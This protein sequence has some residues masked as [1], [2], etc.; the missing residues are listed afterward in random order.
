MTSTV[1]NPESISRIKKDKFL[2]EMSEDKF[3][4][5]VIRPLFY[6]LG[7]RDGRDLCG[8]LEKGKDAIFVEDNRLGQIDLI[9][10]QTKKGNLNL[11]SKA[12][13]NVTTAITQLTTALQTSVPMLKTKRKCYP[14]KVFLCA[15]GKINEHAKHHILEEVKDPRVTFLDADDL[16]PL[17]DEHLPEL[18]LGID[19]E[20]LPYFRAIKELIEGGKA[21]RSA[22]AQFRIDVLISAAT[23]KTFIP[24][25]LYRTA[26][27][28][29]TVHG[30]TI[31]VPD[32]QEVELTTI[33]KQR[34]RKVLILG[35][36]G[37]GKSTALQR[38]AY[39]MVEKGIR[40]SSD[41]HIPIL[42]RAV[43]IHAAQP[44]SLVEYCD[45]ATKKLAKVSNACF[46]V[47]DL[48]AGRVTLL[49]DA[50]DEV[51]EDR[52]REA[53]VELVS[54]FANDYP[55]VQ[56][57]FTSRPY[58]YV[59]DMGSLHNYEV[60]NIS[61]ISWKQADKIVKNLQRGKKL[62]AVNSK[63]LLRRI[64]QVHGIELNPLLVTVF[65][66]TA[67]YSR[68]DIPA[69]I[70]ELFKKFT[71][72]MLG[73]WDESKGLN[74]QYQA[75]LK[76]FLLTK[77]AFYMHQ[78]E[79]TRITISEFEKLV[80]EQ[81]EVR[82]H[83][84]QVDQITEEVLNRSGLFREV[85]DEVEF[86]HHLLQEFFAG[87]GIPSIDYIKQIIIKDWWKRPIVFFFGERP[88]EIAVLGEVMKA[89]SETGHGK[90]VEAA[91]TVGLAV[92]ACYL[93]AVTE[94]LDAWKWVT[95]TLSLA[96]DTALK[97]VDEDGK[98]PV[99]TFVHYYLYGR[100]SVALSNLRDQSEEI[101]RWI[102]ESSLGNSAEQE[103]KLF[104][105]IVALI[106][107]GEVHT[108]KRLV[109]RFKPGDLRYL[110]AIHLGCFLTEE[111][112]ALG[113]DEKQDAHEV[114]KNLERKIELLREQLMKEFGSQLLEVRSGEIKAIEKE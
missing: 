105:F 61:P 30:K 37:S 68:Q 72:L 35:D 31:V 104:W 17:L 44:N 81:L 86:R 91:T 82:G 96:K 63:E 26:P 38:I 100:D 98:Y 62:S 80:A 103:A 24:L 70:T 90:L 50:L 41:Y 52:A 111:V 69:N 54:K 101:E 48:Q 113:T 89:A 108:A 12:T 47:H 5:E 18:W 95:T 79:R 94:K 77:V 25:T 85:G 20:I 40:S 4:D 59:R 46:T 33:T 23:D 39:K 99:T 1:G 19:A 106:E 87:R 49:I 34:A 109:E 93:S 55:N 7:Y 13:E 11:A 32:F 42:L 74:Q 21:E 84:A 57:M 28:R 71:E 27:K 75:P 43:D 65:A 16:V 83:K 58:S 110:L 10:V 102:E 56:V 29:K 92:Q 45:A 66:A 60:Y 114:C 67:E 3:R 78:H 8:P 76:D 22:E 6:R 112:R 73:R 51:A 107:I 97:A 53:V 88:S 2:A 64:E 36:A 15:S 14:N 9:A